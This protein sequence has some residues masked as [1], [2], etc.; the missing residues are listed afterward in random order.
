[1]KKILFKRHFD[2]EPIKHPVLQNTILGLVLGI[3][4]GINLKVIYARIHGPAF[5]WISLFV[6]GLVIGFLSGI[7]RQKWMKRK[8][9]ILKGKKA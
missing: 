5:V 8:G 7:E 3:M 4:I 6:I 2:W 9:V 1:M